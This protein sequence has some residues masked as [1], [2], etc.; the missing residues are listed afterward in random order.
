[1]RFGAGEVRTETLK[2]KPIEICRVATFEMESL[3]SSEESETAKSLPACK[4]VP[5]LVSTRDGGVAKTVVATQQQEKIIRF[6]SR[7]QR[8]ESGLS[9][10]F[11]YS[12]AQL[13]L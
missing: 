7:K 10:V 11:I 9:P 1:M 6:L 5:N 3:E 13:F 8:Q 2:R 12:F 4:A